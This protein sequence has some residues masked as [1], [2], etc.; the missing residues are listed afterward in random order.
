[1]HE[2]WIKVITFQRGTGQ[3]QDWRD[4]KTLLCIILQFKFW[5][6]WM[7]YIINNLKEGKWVL[8][9]KRNKQGEKQNSNQDLPA[10]NQSHPMALNPRL[11]NVDSAAI[12]DTLKKSSQ[13][14]CS[15]WDAKSSG[16]WW[17]P[18]RF[19]WFSCPLRFSWFS[20]VLEEDPLYWDV[21]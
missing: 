10:S 2:K 7:Y 4:S 12:E 6:L 3:T 17:E 20:C 19:S 9:E 13:P 1:M 16:M 11:T 21:S 14:T 8:M 18:L 5:I 15:G